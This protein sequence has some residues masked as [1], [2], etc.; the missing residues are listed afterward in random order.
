MRK[1]CVLSSFILKIIAMVTMAFDHVGLLLETLHPY[2]LDVLQV[3]DIFRIIG[4][5][6]LPLFV[7]M[8]V[9]GVIH[10]KN[11]NKYF[12]RLG[13]MASIISIFFMVLEYSSLRASAHG[14]LR[15]GNIFLD[16]LFVAL[17][18]YLLRQKEIWKK[19]LTLLPLA[20]SILSFVVKGL[21][22]SSN[23]DIQWFPCFL[24]L[25]YDWFSILLG[26]G[27]YASYLVAD[28]Y[29]KMNES[30]NGM[31]KSIWEASGNY[32]VLVNILSLIVLAGVNI[33]YYCAKYYWPEGIFWS[34]N[35]ELY[36]IISGAFILFYSGKRGYN[37][38][39]FQ[40]GSYLY[41]PLHIIIIIVVFIIVN[42]GL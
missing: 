7:F 14:L 10:S 28:S 25:Q 13:I 18:V 42:G 31:D 5:L 26:V 27:F 3:A 35:I 23:I 32:R 38:K 4:R 41:Y 39:W 22:T 30:T 37:A 8:I 33:L 24:T 40:Y 34:V 21:E 17:I 2:D 1:A 15:A 12:L 29:I 6:A 36:S 9:E 19:F 16:L 11:I 20:F